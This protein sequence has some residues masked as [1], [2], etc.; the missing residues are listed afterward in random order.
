MARVGI[1]YRLLLLNVMIVAVPLIG[2]SFARFHEREVLRAME[3]DMIHQAQLL[4]AAL[5]AGRMQD[6]PKVLAAAAH[7]T[8]IR[9]RVLD[10]TGRV[11]ADSAPGASVDLRGRR[12]VR[13]ALAGRYGAATRILEDGRLYLFS[14][15][16]IEADDRIVGA[17]YVMRSTRSAKLA[18][19]R[20]RGS[21]FRVTGAAL[22]VTAVLSLIL[23]SAYEKLTR[24]LDER[25]RQTAELCADIS[26]EFKSP[27]TSMR[28]AAELLLDPSWGAQADPEARGRFL[29][30]ILADTQRLDR[31]VSR[32]L[33]LSRADQTATPP[34]LLAWE[35]LVREVAG[36]RADVE[37]GSGRGTLR[38]RRDQLAAALGNLIDNAVQHAAPGTRPKV[39]VSDA[40][41]GRVRTAVHNQG[42][43]I[44][45][46][47]LPRVWD[48]FFTTRAERGGTGLGLAIVRAVAEAH[49]GSVG[50]TSETPAGTTFWFDLP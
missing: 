24:R 31:L 7:E 30:N 19:L 35:E 40:R 12:E 13:A 16:P 38:G 34:E 37:Y 43:A 49:G 41:G 22:L 8:G 2:I 1:R 23:A 39:I 5:V 36:D 11:V 46:T 14:A 27:L 25:A 4:R 17:V 3:D 21:L 32:L 6:R 9:I 42:T 18:M 50:V 28:G 47:N 15:L 10:E 48:R 29:A 44:R 26:H 33:E 45:A 20:L